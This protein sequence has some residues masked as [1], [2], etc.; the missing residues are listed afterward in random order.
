MSAHPF[1]PP[2]CRTRQAGFSLIEVMIAILIM[3][4]LSLMAWQGL[5]SMI[6]ANSQLEQRT[7]ETARLMRALQQFELDMRER[8]TVE[9]ELDPGLVSAQAE[10]T[11]ADESVAPS[12]GSRVALLPPG[13]MVRSTH[14]TPLSIEWVRAA[15]AQPGYWQRVQWWWQGDALYRALGDP[16]S[17]YP[18]PAPRRSEAVKALQGVSRVALRAWEP[19]QGWRKLPTIQSASA[20]AS[21][22]EL[23]LSVRRSQAPAWTYR[24]VIPLN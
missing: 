23:L 18:L 4:L 5:D 1:P 3:A 20:Q 24:R 6:R 21:G 8:T 19:G 2:A 7:Q 14:Q 22:V 17:V 16:S 13:M 15:P 12:S 9:I 11:S 10:A